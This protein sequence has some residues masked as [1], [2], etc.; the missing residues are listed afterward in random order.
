MSAA[1]T[2]GCDGRLR[3]FTV[4]Y[5]TTR[6]ERAWRDELNA[7][8]AKMKRPAGPRPGGTGWTI[9]TLSS[10]DILE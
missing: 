7:A 9:H 10:R 3:Y 5:V 6:C 2:G 8:G 4:C 1:S